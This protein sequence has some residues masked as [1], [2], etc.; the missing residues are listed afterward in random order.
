VMDLNAIFE[1]LTALK[2]AV[3]APVSYSCR[4]GSPTARRSTTP[5]PRVDV[6]DCAR[7][8]AT[9][10]SSRMRSR[11]TSKRSSASFRRSR[12][13]SLSNLARLIAAIPHAFK[14]KATQPKPDGAFRCS[15]S[16]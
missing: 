1:R 3:Y 14:F 4:P 10:A 6:A 16:V 12:R 5:R 13:S 2:L 11:S 8:S 15:K 7:S 9:T